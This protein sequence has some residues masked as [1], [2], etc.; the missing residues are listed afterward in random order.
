MAATKHKLLESV[1]FTAGQGVS[2]NVQAAWPVLNSEIK[3]EQLA[4]LLV[5]QNRLE[6][7][8]EE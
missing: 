6:E 7:L 3:S 4:G 8:V 1:G 5:L 2:D